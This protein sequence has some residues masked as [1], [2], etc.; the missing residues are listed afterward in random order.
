MSS[1]HHHSELGVG[2]HAAQVLQMPGEP[3]AGYVVAS[4]DL[5]GTFAPIL[6]DR[7]GLGHTGRVLLADHEGALILTGAG[8]ADSGAV[9]DAQVVQAVTE[10]STGTVHYRRISGEKIFSGFTVTPEHGW[11]LVAE[12]E[13]GEA[14]ALL[15][16][17]RRGFVVAGLITLIGVIVFSSRASRR[18]STPLAELAA[19]ARRLRG[20]NPGDRVPVSGGREVAD[21]GR[22]I[23]EMLD[24]VEGIQR[25]RVQAG[26][27]AAVGELSSNVAHEMRNRLSSVKMNLQAVERR[28]RA[29][30]DY[31]ELARIALEQVRSTEE[32]LTDLLNYARPVEPVKESVA[33]GPLLLGLAA[34]FNAE[35]ASRKIGIEVDDRTGGA[36][37]Q[38]DRRLLE[39]ALSNVIRNAL[40]ASSPGGSVTLRATNPDHEGWLHLEVEDDGPGLNG[41]PPEELFRPF[42]TTKERGAGLGL[43]QARKIAELHGGRIFVL[44]G[45][46]GGALFR[47]EIPRKETLA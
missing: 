13:Q 33:L 5:T 19:A 14:L 31:A 2:L 8:E 15:Y 21:V 32:T 35:A 44:T 41:I 40:E 23:N 6:G 1:V 3:P 29:D 28:L 45:T 26:A 7:A 38:A 12:M 17:L 25:Q 16:S 47:L 34:Q 30:D 9:L 43:A 20:A 24:A 22:A 27:L 46:R 37:V 10:V 39:Q 11:L 4:I 36:A 42:F 18:L